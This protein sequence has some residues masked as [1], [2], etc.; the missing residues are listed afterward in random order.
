MMPTFDDWGAAAGL[1]FFF[2]AAWWLTD[3]LGAILS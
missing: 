1:L 2:V 3:I